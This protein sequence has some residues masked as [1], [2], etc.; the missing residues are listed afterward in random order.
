MSHPLVLLDPDATSDAGWGGSIHTQSSGTAA[1]QTDTACVPLGS[2]VHQ[3]VLP[4]SYP[5]R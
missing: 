5:W 1:R 3:A 4:G 2:A